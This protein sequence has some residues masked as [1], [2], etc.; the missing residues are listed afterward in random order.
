MK[1]GLSPIGDMFDYILIDCPPSLGILTMNALA[2]SDGVIIPMQ[3]E[4]YALE[5]LTQ[6][7]VTIKQVKRLYNRGLDITGILVTMYNGR[8]NLSLQVMDE[9]KKYYSGKLFST[10]I[11]RNVRLSEAPGFGMPVLYFDKYSKGARPI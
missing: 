4:F 10:T 6:L 8:L 1:N 2:A 7:M 5:G 3:C 11:M 9:L